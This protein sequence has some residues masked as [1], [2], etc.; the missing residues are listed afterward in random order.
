MN[1]LGSFA[2]IPP[3]VALKVEVDEDQGAAVGQHL[4]RLADD[5]QFRSGIESN[6]RRYAATVLD[7]IRCR[8]LYLSMARLEALKRTAEPAPAR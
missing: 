2:E 8:D 1:N 3:D 5:P 4:I 6:A 7:P